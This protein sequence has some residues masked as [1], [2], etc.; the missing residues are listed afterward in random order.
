MCST[1]PPPKGDLVPLTP[2]DVDNKRFST[3]RVMRQGY[4]MTEVDN[5]LDE[6]AAEMKR[7][8]SELTELREKASARAREVRGHDGGAGLRVE[9]RSDR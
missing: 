3:A 5:F 9:Q 6:V 7:L 4:D 2:E 8:H 1:L